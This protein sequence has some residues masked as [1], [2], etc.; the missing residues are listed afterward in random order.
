MEK[1]D[2]LGDATLRSALLFVRSRSRA[3]TADELAA[4]LDLPRTVARARLERLLAAGLLSAGYE[5]RS[6]RTGPGAGRPA[7]TYA[8]AAETAALEFPRRR[9]ETL[10]LLLAGALPSGRRARELHQ[11]GYAFGTELASAA[12]VRR[13]PRLPGALENLCRALGRLGF[14]AEV[15]TAGDDEGVI[16]SATCPLRPV[17]VADVQA[18]ALD[19]GMWRG[20]LAAATDERVAAHARCETHDCLQETA[21]C[22]IVV[23][24][25]DR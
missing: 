9:Y 4:A 1:L 22:R 7:K 25:T 3:T 5:R 10:I 15:E 19:H 8:A 17:I 13:A 16:V 18:R 14:H 21:P 6:G 20:L 11:V 23:Q 2:A 24:L 12:R